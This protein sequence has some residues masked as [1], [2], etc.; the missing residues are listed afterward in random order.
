MMCGNSG[1]K[2]KGLCPISFGLALGITSALAFL[3][4]SV[5]IMYRGLPPQMAQSGLTLDWSAILMHSLW[6]LVKGFIFGFILA[7]IYDL[8]ICCCRC[9]NCRGSSCACCGTKQPGASCDC[10]CHN[11]G[12]CKC[13]GK[14]GAACNCCS[15]DKKI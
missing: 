8:I 11:N 12:T 10:N 2:K 3:I 4:W 1:A 7:L 9:R 14:A 15:S 13:C 5:W 6:A